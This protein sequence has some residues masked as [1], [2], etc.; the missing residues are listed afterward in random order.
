VT[1][2]A[3]RRVS[4][5][6]TARS[7]AARAPVDVVLLDAECRQTLA[8]LRT[9]ARAGLTTTAVASTS[10]AR[11]A[12]ALQS[13]WC[14]SAATVPSFENGAGP[15]VDSLI[16]LL[17]EHPARM[18]LPA[19]D[20][21]IEAIRSRRQE[22]EARVAIPLASEAALDVAV[23]KERTLALAA[24]L[25]IAVPRSILVERLSDVRAA[26]EEV[27]YPAVIKPVRSYVQKG[28]QGLRVTSDVLT[29]SNQPIGEYTRGMLH[30]GGRVLVQPWL[31]GRREAVSLFYA[32]QRFWAEFAQISHREWP[33]LGGAS[34]LCESVPLAPDLR[35]ASERLVRSMDLEGCSMVEFR[36]DERGRPVLMEV[37]PRMAGSVALAISAGVNFPGLTFAWATGQQLEEVKRY[38]AGRRLRWLAGDIWNLKCALD[39]QGNPDTPSAKVALATF[40]SDFARRPASFDPVAMR[41]PRPSIAELRETVLG[42][43]WGRARRANRNRRPTPN[44]VRP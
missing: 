17:D 6:R 14:S 7:L 5:R 12:P 22:L 4:L 10:M 27:G 24:E 39:H 32:R 16:E 1:I 33:V 40:L 15:Y 41:D 28:G 29:G 19:H 30:W 36:R 13:R 44:E 43:A 42:P 8:C 20:G 35:D 18:L 3:P 21:S 25:G 38:R 34:V 31:P 37:N 26:A 11:W 23:S 9:Y 2:S